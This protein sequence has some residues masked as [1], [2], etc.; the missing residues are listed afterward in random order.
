[1][2]AAYVDACYRNHYEIHKST[3]V[4]L[5]ERIT[6]LQQFVFQACTEKIPTYAPEQ[7]VI[8]YQPSGP[9][10]DMQQLLHSPPAKVVIAL[11]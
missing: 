5:G 3:L 1:M 11:Q 9:M 7:T 4:N 10:L 6:R 2:I 8:P